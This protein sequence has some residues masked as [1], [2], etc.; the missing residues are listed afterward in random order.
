MLSAHTD[1]HPADT[2]HAGVLVSQKV[3]SSNLDH[4][5]GQ[6]DGTSHDKKKLSL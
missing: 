5:I 6:F 3:L 1:G 2:D 4:I